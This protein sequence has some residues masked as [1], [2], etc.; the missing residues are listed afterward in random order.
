MIYSIDDFWKPR[1]AGILPPPKA[2]ALPGWNVLLPANPSFIEADLRL[3]QGYDD[4]SSPLWLVAAPGVVGKSTLAR[5]I[6]AQT[7]AAYLDLSKADTVAGNYLTGGL[8]KNDLLR[9]WQGE[10]MTVLIDALDEARL[11]VTPDSFEDFLRDVKG[12]SVGRRLPTVLFGRV[13]IVEEAWLA[14]SEQDLTPPIFDIEFFDEPRSERFIMAVLDRLAKEDRYKSLATSLAA[15]RPIY[16]DASASLVRNLAN[17]TVSDDAR[18]VGYAPVL[19]AMATDLAD[20]TN[21]TKLAVTIDH[22]MTKQ[23]LRQLTDSILDR[24]AKKIRDQL[25]SVAPRVKSTLYSRAEQL[26]RLGATILGTP[27]PALPPGM[28]QQEMNAYD[29]AVRNLLPQHPF[30]DGTGKRPSGA[31]FAAAIS[32]HT[33]FSAS[34]ETRLAAEAHAGRGPQTPNPFLVDFYLDQA[35]RDPDG[36]PVVPPE[37]VVALYESVRARAS[38]GE[39]ARLSIESGE[40]DETLDV[41][42]QIGGG[43]PQNTGRRLFRTSQAGELRF[44]R[45]VSGVSIDAPSLD[46]VIGAGNPVEILAPIFMNVGCLSFNCSELVVQ[47]EDAAGPDDDTVAS[48]EAAQLLKSDVLTAPLVRKGALLNVSWPGA[49]AYPWTHFAA[50]SSVGDTENIDETLRG[51]RRLILAFQSRSQGGLARFQD[52]IEHRRI[53]KGNIGVAIRERMMQDG[54]LTHEGKWYFLDPVLL[55]KVVGATYQQL[56]LKCFNDRVR[57]YASSISL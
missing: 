56:K 51:I 4:L 16:R 5:E 18:F 38:A 28:S 23:V 14:L 46:V 32:T 17:L 27:A 52:K 39:V 21:P 12:L 11:R 22:T 54:I 1:L 30:L 24:E 6:A 3:R 49:T 26:D 55:G 37:H 47:L 36:I 19:E 35:D 40:D 7:G 20:V 33:L 41:E 53:T 2:P 25:D 43:G 57:S 15:H 34:P 50:V 45:Q 8:F 48:I 29:N 13:G 44:G 31:V 9:L 10:E 42:I